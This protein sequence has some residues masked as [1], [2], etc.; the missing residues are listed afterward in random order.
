MKLVI[1]TH[2]S[3]KFKEIQQLLEGVPY[4]I[5]SADEVGVTE[6][7]AEDGATLEENAFKKAR[8]TAQKVGE[9]SVAD[10][11]GLFIDALSG[12]PGI[13]A[14]RWAGQGA[15]G[16]HLL[17][18]TLSQLY[19]IPFEKRTARF[20]TVSALV[21]PQGTKYFFR[22]I[23]RGKLCE[24]PRGSHPEKLPYD[25][26]FVPEGETLTYAEMPIEKKNLISHR[27]R[28][29]IELRKFLILRR[30]SLDAEY[31]E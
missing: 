26:L 11:T 22:G 7:I 24:S 30:N 29:F 1:A 27:A 21:S 2:N 20:E 13:Y 17:N 9:W 25:A 18:Y 19:G 14:S 16:A 28:T 12:R 4:E 10:D 31:R 23:T 8:Y 5:I 3:D 6:D 15:R